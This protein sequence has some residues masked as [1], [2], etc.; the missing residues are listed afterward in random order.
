[1]AAHQYEL[2]DV[3]VEGQ[4]VGAEGVTVGFMVGG[5]SM[6]AA[7]FCREARRKGE[8]LAREN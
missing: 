5:S 1:M 3:F 6:F 4:P 8:N 7:T 2:V